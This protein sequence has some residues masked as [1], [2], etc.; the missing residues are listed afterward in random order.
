MSSFAIYNALIGYL[1]L[2]RDV[3]TLLTLLFF[4]RRWRRVSW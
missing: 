4:A 1:L 2:H 3:M